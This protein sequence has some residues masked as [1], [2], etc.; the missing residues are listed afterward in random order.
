MDQMKPKTPFDVK[1]SKLIV[2]HNEL[3]FKNLASQCHMRL[4]YA[5]KWI[6]YRTEILDMAY[7]RYS[8]NV[9]KYMR[10][11]ELLYQIKTNVKQASLRFIWYIDNIFLNFENYKNTVM[12]QGKTRKNIIKYLENHIKRRFFVVKLNKGIEQTYKLINTVTGEPDKE[13]NEINQGIYEDDLQEPSG[14]HFDNEH[15]H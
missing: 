11:R 15:N 2:N 6:E 14:M 9:D 3:Q 5:E 13:V 8:I 4:S 1:D 12:F 10:D 7:D